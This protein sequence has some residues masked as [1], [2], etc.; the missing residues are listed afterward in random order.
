MAR[1][2]ARMLLPFSG[3]GKAYFDSS[4]NENSRGKGLLDGKDKDGNSSK[5]KAACSFTFRE[6]AT[7]TRNF[8]AANLI[9][10]GGFGRV[11]KGRLESG[12]A[13]Y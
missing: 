7:A 6:L 1:G 13:S 3:R 9:G 11:Y 2:E 4:G 5:C 10:E 8:K 12:Q